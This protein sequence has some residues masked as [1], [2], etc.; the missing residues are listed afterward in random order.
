MATSVN[1]REACKDHE[2]KLEHKPVKK[3]FQF[4]KKHS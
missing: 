3:R 2:L 1:Q 4:V